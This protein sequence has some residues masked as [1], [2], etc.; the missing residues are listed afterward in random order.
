ME[1][2]AVGWEEGVLPNARD[3]ALSIPIAVET[4]DVDVCPGALRKLAALEPLLNQPVD[5]PGIG[6]EVKSK[7]N[8]FDGSSLT[9]R[10]NGI[11]RSTQSRASIE[12]A[13]GDG[14]PSGRWAEDMLKLL[15][16]CW[17]PAPDGAP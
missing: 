11:F 14:H 10:V 2:G 6:R 8:Y 5:I 13:A 1:W 17:R 3:L 9:L 16:P 4:A 15:E 12:M 7:I